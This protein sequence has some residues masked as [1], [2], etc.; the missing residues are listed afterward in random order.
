MKERANRTASG[1]L[2]A[3]ESAALLGALSLAGAS[4]SL[5]RVIT[6]R[7]KADQDSEP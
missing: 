4:V 7:A 1:V 6:M 5:Y 3:P 2:A